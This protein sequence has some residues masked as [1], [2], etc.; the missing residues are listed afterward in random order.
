MERAD[1]SDM[2]KFTRSAEE[3]KAGI[4]KGLDPREVVI[5]VAKA[6][7]Y[8]PQWTSR[9]CEVTN[10]ILAVS[11]HENSDAEKRASVYPTVDPASVVEEL[12]PTKIKV[13][14]KAASAKPA[15]STVYTYRDLQAFSKAAAAPATPDLNSGPL[16]NIP[17]PFKSSQPIPPP[18][19]QMTPNPPPPSAPLANPQQTVHQGPYTP[20]E[21]YATQPQQ[22][23][24]G[25]SLSDE[26]RLHALD[27]N[28]K[29]K[30]RGQALPFPQFAEPEK[31]PQQPQS[32]YL[33]SRYSSRRRRGLVQ[34]PQQQAPLTWQDKQLIAREVNQGNEQVRNSMQQSNVNTTDLSNWARAGGSN[35]LPADA[36]AH[37]AGKDWS[38][39]TAEVRGAYAA[40]NDPRVSAAE[41]QRAKAYIDQYGGVGDVTDLMWQNPPQDWLDRANAARAAQGLG[42]MNEQTA[43]EEWI[44]FLGTSGNGKA[45]RAFAAGKGNTVP[46][47]VNVLGPAGLG[48]RILTENLYNDEAFGKLK[49]EYND[50]A[51]GRS[52][53][54]Q[55][56]QEVQYA[57]REGKI[58][59]Q[60]NPQAWWDGLSKDSRRAVLSVAMGHPSGAPIPKQVLDSIASGQFKGMGAGTDPKKLEAWWAALPEH[61]RAVYANLATASVDRAARGDKRTDWDDI[62]TDYENE[63]NKHLES[64]GRAGVN[65]YQHDDAAMRSRLHNYGVDVPDNVD[66]NAWVRQQSAVNPTIRN[67]MISEMARKNEQIMR[68]TQ[69]AYVPQKTAA[70]HVTN[71][72]DLAR[73]ASA[74]RSQLIKE[75][76]ETETF[77]NQ[78]AYKLL[79]QFKKTAAAIEASGKS[80]DQLEE[81]AISQFGS[82][83]KAMMNKLAAEYLKK[84]SRYTGAPRLFTTNPWDTE[85]YSSI[86]NL[87]SEVRGAKLMMEAA[88]IEKQAKLNAVKILEA[89]LANLSKKAGILDGATTAG[90]YMLARSVGDMAKDKIDSTK[91]QVTPEDWRH[92]VSPKSLLE[93]RS[94]SLR[95][96]LAQALKD[97]VIEKFPLHTVVKRYNRLV[98]ATPR[99][100]ESSAM[101]IPLLR[102]Q[103]EVPDVSTFDLK[104]MQELEKGERERA[105]ITGDKKRDK[106]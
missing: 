37:G 75:A 39:E 89:N 22:Q 54:K 74:A 15:N 24:L 38:K 63:Y 44:G 57:M 36:Y 4:E 83:A 34:Q 33:G 2:I 66:V 76:K 8:N 10:R 26:Q 16:S 84:A 81:R 55:L 85:P 62:R 18:Q 3:V 53:S 93:M 100:A 69:N 56:P 5:K 91:K 92:G 20:S 79:G 32:Q 29:A 23:Q 82:D 102:Q 19:Q 58:P 70:I 52:T 42:K 11:M 64:T 40:L 80:F 48:K 67:F 87:M 60:A 21:G 59:N 43:K 45:G 104:S 27:E 103:L 71:S 47:N 78:L 41:K 46:A 13:A 12:F 50:S 35:T 25:A 9:L 68:A 90:G 106:K 28:A 101:L 73:R 14:T 30:N 77:K 97:P 6:A 99:A 51:V 96:A 72:N 98:E 1:S 17:S 61:E 88:S 95:Q 65:S 94:I 31:A 7:S 49:T 105:D 86:R